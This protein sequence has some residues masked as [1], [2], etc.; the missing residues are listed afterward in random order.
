MQFHTI[1]KSMY[2]GITDLLIDK[3]QTKIVCNEILH[4]HLHLNPVAVIARHE[5]E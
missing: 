3:K 2:T 4:I 5:V 1:D